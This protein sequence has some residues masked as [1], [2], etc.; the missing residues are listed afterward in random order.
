MAHGLKSDPLLFAEAPYAY[1][2]SFRLDKYGRF[3]F[4]VKL[5]RVH[6][7]KF[8]LGFGQIVGDRERETLITHVVTAQSDA[9]VVRAEPGYYLWHPLPGK[10]F[11]AK[12]AM[13]HIPRMVNLPVRIVHAVDSDIMQQASRSH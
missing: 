8:L 1:S 10:K 12:Y 5:I 11:V 3:G 7:K 2:V 4:T 9:S 6:D 13:L